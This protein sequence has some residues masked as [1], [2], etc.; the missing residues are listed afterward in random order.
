MRAWGWVLSGCHDLIARAGGKSDAAACKRVPLTKMAKSASLRKWVCWSGSCYK[1][2]AG[3]NN[4]LIR[5]GRKGPHS[6]SHTEGA[7]SPEAKAGDGVTLLGY[8]SARQSKRP[9]FDCH[10]LPLP[11]LFQVVELVSPFGKIQLTSD[12]TYFGA[13]R[14]DL[15]WGGAA[16]LSGHLKRAN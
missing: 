13:S 5:P 14:V 16:Q 8:N 7:W 11:N 2:R 1:R 15:T 10:H 6:L 3:V 9:Y 4:D 12:H